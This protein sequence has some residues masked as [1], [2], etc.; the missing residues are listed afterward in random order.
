[1]EIIPDKRDDG[2]E[3]SFNKEAQE[4]PQP[5]IE[6]SANSVADVVGVSSIHLKGKIIGKEVSFLVDTGAT[7]NFIDP[8]IA[9]RV[10][11]QPQSMNLFEVEVADGKKILVRSVESLSF[12]TF[13]GMSLALTC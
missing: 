5:P 10:R 6:L 8:T 11:L 7:H 12:Y 3:W 13:K 4:E 1:M 2:V 9:R